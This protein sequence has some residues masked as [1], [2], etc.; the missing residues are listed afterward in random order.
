MAQPLEFN[1]GVKTKRH[2]AI[3]EGQRYAEAK[4]GYRVFP[5]NADIDLLDWSK[6]VVGKVRVTQATVKR[7]ED[8]DSNDAKA[9]GFGD[10]GGLM[11]YLREEYPDHG[12]IIS[13]VGFTLVQRSTR[14]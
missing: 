1:W 11:V 5:M 4:G 2:E 12:G 3:T 7:V 9:C 8:L 6:R 10:V 13:I 14:T